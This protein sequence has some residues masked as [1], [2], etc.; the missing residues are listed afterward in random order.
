[1]SAALLVLGLVLVALGVALL[2]L[3][4]VPAIALIFAGVAGVAWADDFTRIG[5]PTLAVLLLLAIVGSLADNVATLVGA[6]RAGA[7]GWGVAGAGVGMLV[8]LIFGLPGIIVGPAVGAFLFE[9]FRNPDLKRAGMA[10]LGGFFGFV[11]GVV[12]KSFFG[13]LIVGLAALAYFV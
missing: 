3:P 13:L 8:G 10:G 4:A 2:A 1:M 7:S 11:L 6:R 9:L 12:A 5:V